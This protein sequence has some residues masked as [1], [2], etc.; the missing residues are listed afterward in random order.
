MASVITLT[1]EGAAYVRVSTE[2]QD[3]QRQRE[4]IV[5][6]LASYS[7]EVQAANWYVDHGWRRWEASVRPAWQ[8]LLKDAEAGRIKWIVIDRQDRAESADPF[9]TFSTLHLLR[10]AGCQLITVDDEVLT[11]DEIADS[12][13][14]LLTSKKS[15]EEGKDKAIRVLES[16]I[17]RV[18]RGEWQGGYIPFGMDVAALD[19]P[20]GNELWRVQIVRKDQRVKI[21]MDTGRTTAFNGTGNFPAKDATTVLQL[22][23]TRDDE[24]LKIVRNIFRWYTEEAVTTSQIAKRLNLMGTPAQYGGYWQAN[25]ISQILGNSIYLGR[26]RW[27]RTG[28]GRYVEFINGSRRSVTQTKGSRIRKRADWIESV[29]LF[30]PVIDAQTWEKAQTI[31]QQREAGKR[32]PAPRNAALY[33]SGMLVCVH[34]GKP[35]RGYCVSGKKAWAGYICGTYADATSKGKSAKCHRNPLPHKLV[36]KYVIQ[37]LTDQGTAMR[38]AKGTKVAPPTPMDGALMRMV[39]AARHVRERLSLPDPPLVDMEVMVERYAVAHLAETPRIRLQ[40][41]KLEQEHDE[42]TDSVLRLP[43]G[44]KRAIEKT[45]T[46]IMELEGKIKE[47]EDQLTDWS[48][49]LMDAM[50][51]VRKQFEAWQ[52][53]YA[54]VTG[55]ESHRR[56]AA[57]IRKVIERIVCHFADTGMTH[58][59]RWLSRIE[60]MPA[61]N[62][63]T[64]ATL[65]CRGTS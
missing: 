24:R 59:K 37:Y 20:T 10:R 39:T 22:R 60:I 40:L 53:A 27:N 55:D 49:Q 2:Q 31:S 62:G 47:A 51:E 9:E 6:W 56:R 43:S 58:P 16:Q 28:Q 57:A 63:E 33:Y 1:G 14:T 48:S 52:A 34:C 25:N 61:V 8:K 19:A 44:A 7:A 12:V 46:R 4:A 41:K 35:M 15:S 13:R 36:E 42:L 5:R 45:N 65:G 11:S 3:E 64:S 23:P 50:Q 17:I 32:T 26:M 21:E 30:P 29:Q 54:A 38:P 18:R